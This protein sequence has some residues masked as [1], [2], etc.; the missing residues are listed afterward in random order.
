MLPCS[1]TGMLSLRNEVCPMEIY[2]QANS[3]CEQQYK[4]KE[5]KKLLLHKRSPAPIRP[6]LGFLMV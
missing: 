5:V 1:T 2:V 4:K 6:G 3:V